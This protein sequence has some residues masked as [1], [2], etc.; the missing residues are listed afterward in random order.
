[1][2]NIGFLLLAATLLVRFF[3]SGGAPMLKMM[4]GPA[5]HDHHARDA[6]AAVVRE[7]PGR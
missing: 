6:P 7:S 1:M 2:F 5:D 3:G 4:G